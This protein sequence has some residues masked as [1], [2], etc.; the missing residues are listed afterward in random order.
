MIQETLSR[1][2]QPALTSDRWH[3]VHACWSG[4]QEGRTR[5]ERAIVSEHDDRLAACASARELV[6]R[7]SAE[8][9]ARAPAER[10]QLFVRKPGF[11]S[12]KTAGRLQRRRR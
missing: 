4:A 9:E 10:D 11:R 8:M 1:T 2:R 3:V 5:F 12:L 6:T 7:L